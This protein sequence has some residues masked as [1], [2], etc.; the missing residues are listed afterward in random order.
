MKIAATFAAAAAVALSVTAVVAQSDP[1]TTR[2]NL[3]KENGR[4]ALIAVR[5]MRGQAPYDVAA[6]DAAFSQWADT[7]QKLP[8]LFPDNAKTGGDNR[9]SPKIWE[10]KKDFEAKI[11]EFSKAIADNRGKAKESV[12]GLKAA[13]AA[14]GKACD[15]CHK[16]YR[17]SKQ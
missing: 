13:V 11:A 9:A 4:H 6:V 10:N 14:V 3:M 5:M 8:V 15:D 7:A 1:V 12:D 17:L 2:E 16:D